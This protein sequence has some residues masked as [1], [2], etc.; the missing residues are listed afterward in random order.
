MAPLRLLVLSLVAA[1]LSAQSAAELAFQARKAENRGEYARA[2]L[3][4][5]QAAALDSN[6][7][8]YWV[9]S[10][11]LRTKA[12]EE[13]KSAAALANL[14]PSSSDLDSTLVD[15][16]DGI[17]GTISGKELAEA[18]KPLPPKELKASA[19][20][21]S[22]DLR[23]PGKELFE[24]VARAFGL[25]VVFDGDFPAGGQP[26]QL[27]LSDVDYRDALRALQAAT[28]TFIF[29]VS[30]R[31]F[32][33]ARDTPQKRAEIEPTASITIPIPEP[34]TVQEAQELARTV[35]QAMEI[36]KFTVDSTQRLVLLRDRVSKVYLAQALLDQLL[37]AKP[38]VLVEVE[39]MEVHSDTTTHWGANLPSQFSLLHLSRLPWLSFASAPS[40][41][42]KF[43]TF[44]GG[45]TMFGLGL[46]NA[47]LFASMTESSSR[48]LI[49]TQ[50][51]TV[52]GTPATLHIG[53]RYPVVSATYSAGTAVSGGSTYMPPPMFNFEDLGVVLKITPRIHSPE[54]MSLAVEAEYKVLTGTVLNGVPVIANR[55]FSST[56]RLRD[57]QWAILGGLLTTSEARSISGL[58]GLATLPV[59]GP[60]LRDNSREKIKG[61]VLMVIRPRVVSLPPD[62]LVNIRTFWLGSEGRP[63]SGL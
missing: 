9:R 54:Q 27:R 1:C 47:Q 19:E 50:L 51:R 28:G 13:T 3:L 34:V 45:A 46:T 63:L 6:H 49:R 39:F 30:D 21:K 15:E 23:A 40:G 57:G 37:S 55:K 35:Q 11:L 4:Y 18:K 42:L 26:V 8:E 20:R 41:F 53:D 25:D 56:V 44:G 32:M 22:F 10:Q 5:A 38:Q 60:L 33:A 36:P 16:P 24:K 43:L 48:T 14:P 29:P 17:L 62:E 7:R 52:E 59:L 12:L 58:Y 31:L 2:Y 61:Q